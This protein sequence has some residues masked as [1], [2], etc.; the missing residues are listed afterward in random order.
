MKKTRDFGDFL[1]FLF[2]IVLVGCGETMNVLTTDPAYKVTV[3]FDPLPL[4]E[5]NL[6]RENTPV[7]PSVVSL[8]LSDTSMQRVTIQITDK[9]NNGVGSPIIYSVDTSSIVERKQRAASV[10]DALFFSPFFLPP[11]LLPG[12]Y[13]MICTVDGEEGTLGTSQYEFYYLGKEAFSIKS[14]RTYPPGTGSTYPM[15]PP[16]FP[17]LVETSFDAGEGLA[18]YIEWYGGAAKIA[19]G[20]IKNGEHTFLWQSPSKEGTVVLT[21][22]IYPEQPLKMGLTRP[23]YLTQK[24]SV[25]VSK[26]ASMPRLP[27]ANY[28]YEVI[29]HFNGNLQDA[30]TKTTPWRSISGQVQPRWKGRGNS[31][32]MV[33][34]YQDRY[35]FDTTP[36]LKKRGATSHSYLWRFSPYATKGEG[37]LATVQE[38]DLFITLRIKEATLIVEAIYGTEKKEVSFPFPSDMV[39]EEMS[40]L[41]ITVSYGINSS[42]DTHQRGTVGNSLPPSAEEETILLHCQWYE[43]SS[44]LLF[45]RPKASAEEMRGQVTLGPGRD[46]PFDETTNSIP[47]FPLFIIDEFGLFYE[48]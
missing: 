5:G 23:P 36:Y 39:I 14:I 20:Y 34:G 28:Q 7:T 32:G 9:R 2:S 43:G 29:T 25:F 26:K 46:V 37:V 48:K 19:E 18:P 27:E 15:V 35:V 13:R 3:Q 40:D 47:A 17:I 44:S 16:D 24:I 4:A 31:Y 6:V 8:N 30:I 10:S 38:G 45:I 21:A 33:I 11:T 1:V 41:Q 42:P 12:P 22:R